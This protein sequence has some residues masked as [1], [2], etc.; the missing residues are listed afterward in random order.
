MG[1][2]HGNQDIS[3]LY[4][5]QNIK[6]HQL[7]DFKHFVYAM[8]NVDTEKKIVDAILKFTPN[9]KIFLHR[10]L[11]QTNTLVLQGEHRFY[12]PNGTLKEVRLA[13]TYTAT[14]AD[15]DPHSEGGGNEGAIVLYSIRADQKEIFE[16]LDEA[17]NVVAILTLQDFLDVFNEQ[18]QLIA[19]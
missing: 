18:R 5:H 4:N 11:A 14:P 15:P 1:F 13:G 12:E 3:Y 16:I 6:W 10:H 8:I 2:L 17:L 9:E 7:G 19:A